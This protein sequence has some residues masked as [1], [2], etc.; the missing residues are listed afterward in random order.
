MPYI[1]NFKDWLK[2]E[3]AEYVLTNGG[4]EMPKY[5]E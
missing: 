5:V 4:Y 1:G 2:P 3:W